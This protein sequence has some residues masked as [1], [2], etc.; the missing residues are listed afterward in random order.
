MTNDI[1]GLIY[2]FVNLLDGKMYIGKT[3][4]RGNMKKF[5][6]G[7]YV[8]SSPKHTHYMRARLHHGDENFK[9]IIL[10]FIYGDKHELNEAD[11]IESCT[12]MVAVTI[13]QRAERTVATHSPACRPG[14]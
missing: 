13:M 3:T 10:E 2:C 4:A 8:G 6:S 5:F 1:Y 9:G 11:Q 14:W 7:V 12:G